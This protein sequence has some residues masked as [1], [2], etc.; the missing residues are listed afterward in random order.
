MR[1]WPRQKSRK[2]RD[3][4]AWQR[5]PD[6]LQAAFGRFSAEDMPDALRPRPD[7]GGAE[8]FDDEI[9]PEWRDP[10]TPE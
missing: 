3:R 1:L 9:E 8:V 5:S 10:E 6:P 7:A 4:Q 2:R